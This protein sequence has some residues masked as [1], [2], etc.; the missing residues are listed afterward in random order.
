MDGISSKSVMPGPL[1]STLPGSLL[2]IQIHKS[3]PRTT[4]PKIPV[5]E[6]MHSPSLSSPDVLGGEE[7]GSTVPH[8]GSPMVSHESQTDFG[9]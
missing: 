5:V 9:L 8:W 6:L 7:S 3:H 4:E 1:I 2:K